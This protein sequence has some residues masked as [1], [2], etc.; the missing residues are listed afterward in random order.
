MLGFPI[1]RAPSSKDLILEHLNSHRKS[2][3]GLPGISD[4]S[5]N[6]QPNG[7]ALRFELATHPR[8][9]H[10]DIIGHSA[11]GFPGS[12]GDEALAFFQALKDGTIESYLAANPKALAFVQLPKPFPRSLATQRF[13]SVNAF[14][15]V[16]A[17]GR[18]T[19]VRYRIVPAAGFET[20]SDDE[21]KTK[22]KDYLFE[23]LP[24]LVEDGPLVFKLAAQVAEDSDVTDDACERWPEERQVVELGTISLA[25][26]VEDDAVEQKHL[27]FDPVPRDIPGLEP[28]ADPLLDVRAALYLLSG[29]ERRSA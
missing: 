7:F 13:F 22:G 17:E 3:T 28:S 29:R 8:R 11:D 24:T 4:A 10:T 9:Q 27:I 26:F 18:G 16:D 5:S 6:A 14:K 15:L 20:L 21:M 12:N 23:E 1:V 2:A 25:G 19:Y